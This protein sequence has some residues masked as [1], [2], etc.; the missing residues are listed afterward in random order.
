VNWKSKRINERKLSL[1]FQV[2]PKAEKFKVNLIMKFGNLFNL[3]VRLKVDIIMVSVIYSKTLRQD[4]T[5]ACMRNE[6][7]TYGLGCKI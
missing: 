4:W 3:L 2:F 1:S 7:W 5:A 6:K